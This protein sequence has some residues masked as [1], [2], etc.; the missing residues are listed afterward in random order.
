MGS[1]MSTLFFK[2]PT[3]LIEIVDVNRGEAS[4]LRL[5]I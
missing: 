2:N 5:I 3:N 4:P 1:W